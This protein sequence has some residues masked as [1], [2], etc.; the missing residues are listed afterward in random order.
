MGGGLLFCRGWGVFFVAGATCFVVGATFGGC[1][2][3]CRRPVASR[4]GVWEEG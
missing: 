4:G 2:N 1:Q 3:S